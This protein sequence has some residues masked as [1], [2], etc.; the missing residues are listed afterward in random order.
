M[1][2]NRKCIGKFVQPRLYS[3]S[4]LGDTSSVSSLESCCPVQQLTIIYDC[5]KAACSDSSAR[6]SVPIVTSSS[7]TDYKFTVVGRCE[8]CNFV[9]PAT[10]HFSGQQAAYELQ[11]ALYTSKHQQSQ[12]AA[13]A[14][15]TALSPLIAT[16]DLTL[17]F[18]K[19]WQC[20]CWLLSKQVVLSTHGNHAWSY[21][22]G[23]GLELFSAVFEPQA[24]SAWLKCLILKFCLVAQSSLHEAGPCLSASESSVSSTPQQDQHSE[25]IIRP[26]QPVLSSNMPFTNTKPLNKKQKQK[27]NSRAAV[28]A[29]RH[30][31][32]PKSAVSTASKEH[33]AELTASVRSN[34]QQQSKQLMA[35]PAASEDQAA[36]V[37]GFSAQG[38]LGAP[39]SEGR[40]PQQV[41]WHFDSA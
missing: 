15:V 2:C 34:S 12:A 25:A 22:A 23:R 3:V 37:N 21:V 7:S 38:A 24:D 18:G 9:L 17:N 11:K 39:S 30:A 20:W 8:G 1:Y 35:V 27:Q 28:H 41:A 4:Q 26:T 32:S 16:T 36:G 14:F 13:A 33:K 31:D 40:Y 6:V 19:L 10:Y 5:F 29:N